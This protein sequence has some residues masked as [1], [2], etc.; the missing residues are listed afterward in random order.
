MIDKNVANQF[1]VSNVPTLIGWNASMII[2]EILDQLNGTY[3]K[4]DMMM[5]L[6]NDTHF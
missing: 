2:R 6:T 5:L 3:R 1:N 4:P